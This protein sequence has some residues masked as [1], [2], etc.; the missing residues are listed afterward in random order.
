MSRFVLESENQKKNEIKHN[1][2]GISTTCQLLLI[3]GT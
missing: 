1:R 2:V 3:N